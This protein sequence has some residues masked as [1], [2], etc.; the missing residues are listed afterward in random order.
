MLFGAAKLPNRDGIEFWVLEEDDEI[1]TAIGWL[2][3]SP[4]NRDGT[5]FWV[6]EE[7]DKTEAVIG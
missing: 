6:L 1:E 4:P 7:D 2:L 5:G 3:A